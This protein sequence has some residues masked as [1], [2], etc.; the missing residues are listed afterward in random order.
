MLTPAD[1]TIQIVL[2]ESQVRFRTRRGVL[3]SRLLEGRFPD[4]EEVIPK[5]FARRATVGT[6]AFA[7]ALRRAALLAP[8]GARAVRLTFEPGGVELFSRSPD[9]GE[10]VVRIEGRYEAEKFV[11]VFNP[12]LLADYLKVVDA[13]EIEL[14]MNSPTSAALLRGGKDYTYVVMPLQMSL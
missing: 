13:G 12:D 1:E 14:N 10:A 9:V 11:I 6:E 5:E 7:A 3:A 4:Y 2:D 8:E